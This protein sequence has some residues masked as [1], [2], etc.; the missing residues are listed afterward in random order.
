MSQLIPIPRNSR[1]LLGAINF[2][3]YAE[4]PAERYFPD[5]FVHNY[6]LMYC[7]AMSGFGHM[8]TVIQNASRYF[9]FFLKEVILI[10]E[11]RQAV[12]MTTRRRMLAF[13]TKTI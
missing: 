11:V 8:K 2:T 9:W 5:F 7:Q 3:W 4:L 12:K 13:L 10:K 1:A 6:A